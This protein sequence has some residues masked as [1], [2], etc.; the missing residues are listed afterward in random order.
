ML[1]A[2]DQLGI[3]PNFAPRMPVIVAA[4]VF[5][6]LVCLALLALDACRSWDA[7]NI[8]L[9]ENEVNASNLVRSLAQHAE[10]VFIQADTVLV[11]LTERL[12]NDGIEPARLRRLGTLM[13]AHV[14]ELPQLHGLFIYD[15]NGSW[16]A[17]SLHLIPN[18]VN[19]SDRFYFRYHRNHE[20]RGPYIG[21][22]IVSRS[23]GEWILTMSRRFNRPDG[24][25][26][27]VVLATIHMDYFVRFYQTFGIGK[28]GIII[29]A[30][31]DGTQLA[32]YPFVEEQ[33]GRNLKDSPPFSQQLLHSLQGT[34]ANNPSSLDGIDRITSYRRPERLPL[35]AAVSLARHEV[36][37]SWWR[38]AWQSFVMVA[39]LALLLGA[40]G[41][42]LAYHISLHIE[43]EQKLLEVRDDLQG[44]NRQLESIAMQDGLTG[45]A[46]RRQFDTM[47]LNEFNRAMRNQHSLALV[48][49]DVDLFKQ[50]NDVYGHPAGD[51]CLRLIAHS[52]LACQKRP[53]DLA[54]RYGGE[55]IAVL[56]PDTDLEGAHL[57]AES[58]RLAISGLAIINPRSP[59]GIIT[60]S[61]GVAAI[62]PEKGASIPMDLLMAADR[63]LYRAKS[64]GRNQIVSAPEVLAA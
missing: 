6:V 50:Y 7:Y 24:S 41:L 23:T 38:D 63:A 9:H 2:Q 31:N 4:K 57:V 49:I 62:V 29:L 52:I 28:Q 45:L 1:P 47:L 39:V 48:M 34:Y 8:K 43:A 25:F 30:L 18:K 16:L 37:A 36:L 17:N 21:A 61:C 10:D 44:L 13:Q 33:V 11:S 35:V 51:E 26:G 42:R 53:G 59:N 22:P 40:M 58:I 15:D 12:E 55:E 5:V 27:G 64:M 19:N 56:L 20:D 60:V 3:A 32:Q 14:K 46:N 54:A